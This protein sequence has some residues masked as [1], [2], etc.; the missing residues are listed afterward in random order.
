MLE[1]SRILIETLTI[2]QR[3]QTMIVHEVFRLRDMQVLSEGGLDLILHLLVPLHRC[4]ERICCIR[5]SD[6]FDQFC[7][8]IDL[9]LFCLQEFQSIESTMFESIKLSWSPITTI[10][11]NQDWLAIG[12]QRV[13]RETL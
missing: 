13:D 2:G 12:L 7:S 6:R 4:L 5:V 1:Q 3:L 11:R 9:F 8:H 10:D